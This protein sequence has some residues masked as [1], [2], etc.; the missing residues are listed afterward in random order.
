MYVSLMIL[1]LIESFVRQT[2]LP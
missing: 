1:S 2:L